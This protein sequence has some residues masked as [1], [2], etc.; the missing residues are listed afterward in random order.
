M[1]SHV[2]KPTSHRKR[3]SV[4]VA[5]AALAVGLGSGSASAGTLFVL[6]P[7]STAGT[8]TTGYAS[9]GPSAFDVTGALALANPV[10]ACS[11]LANAAD[12]A[13]K[14]TLVDRGVCEF[15]MK[16]HNAQEA[17]V[18]AVV[19]AN[20]VDGPAPDMAPTTIAPPVG[21]PTVSVTRALGDQLKAALLAEPVTVRL[22]RDEEPPVLA[23]PATVSAEA[24]GPEGAAVS[25]AVGASDNLEANPA[26]SCSPPSG[27]TFALG[28]T[29]L[30]CTATDAAGNSATGTFV[31]H[32]VDTTPP[33]LV[34]PGTITV[35]A[36][37]PAGAVVF[38]EVSA[39]DIA[40]AF[41]LV[42]SQASGTFPIGATAVGC[43]ATDDAG[44]VTTGTF[45]VVVRSATQQIDNVITQVKS[46][47]AKEGVADSLDAKLQ[48]VV[49]A[50]NSANAGDTASACNKLDAFINEVRA[51]T[52]PGKSLTQA[53]GDQLILDAQRIKNVIGCA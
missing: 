17:G 13:G 9:F 37:S 27:S 28:S 19:V 41:T 11:P 2:H 20:N 47:N 24:T 45:I 36:T 14:I 5:A 35:N 16:A 3:L 1:H 8:Y 39:T 32:V 31:V 18:L 53:D 46:V 30:T 42:C 26:V 29:A 48:N 6:S 50:L 40:S 25:Y 51:Q 33:T 49:A 10:G 22:F 12:V 21:I 7:T 43:T 4:F 38:F 15:A 23:L 44:N 34:L 52:G